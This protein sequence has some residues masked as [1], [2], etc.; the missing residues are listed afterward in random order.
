MDDGADDDSPATVKLRTLAWEM[1][2]TEGQIV[3]IVQTG[4]SVNVRAGFVAEE[5]HAGTFNSD[6]VVKDRTVRARTD[7]HA[8]FE[9][10]GHARNGV[11]DIV[12][13]DGATVLDRAQSKYYQTAEKTAAAQRELAADGSPK[14]EGQSLIVPADQ[15]DGVRE[16]AHRTSLKETDGRQD[17]KAAAEMVKREATDRLREGQVESAP[18][19]LASSKAIVHDPHGEV[20]RSLDEPYVRVAV[21]LVRDEAQAA[22][23]PFDPQRLLRGD[24]VD[25]LIN[26]GRVNDVLSEMDEDGSI[27]LT[28]EFRSTDPDLS[29]DE[30]DHHETTRD[31]IRDV[32]AKIEAVDTEGNEDD[33]DEDNDDD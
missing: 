18:L 28:Y 10:T 20:R 8:D 14:Y 27:V 4:Q 31:F 3:D 16:A 23:Q 5:V 7:R 26:N 21:S 24:T 17:V 29:E 25:R 13:V 1:A 30:L 9:S 12:I 33:V 22:G 11:S 15:L 6:A 2:E 19:P 32:A